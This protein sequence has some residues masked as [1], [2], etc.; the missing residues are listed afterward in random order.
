MCFL[1]T[2]LLLPKTITYQLHPY[3][4]HF[5]S[6]DPDRAAAIPEIGS[7]SFARSALCKR[8]RRNYRQIDRCPIG[9]FLT[10][11]P[12]LDEEIA[13]AKSMS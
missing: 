8:L 12:P 11:A 10:F 6:M 9:A 1:T 5:F 3:C 4:K 7:F 2:K 13:Q